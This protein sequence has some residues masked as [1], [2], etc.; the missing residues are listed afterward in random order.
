MPAVYGT[1][2]F[3]EALEYLR[4]KLALPTRRW[5]DLLGAAHDRAFVVAGAVRA[6]LLT[7]LQAAVVKARE[8]GTTLAEFRK[9]FARIAAERGW[10]GWTGE[11]SKGGRAWR[12]RVIYETNLQTSYQAGRYQQMKAVAARRPYW[13]YRHNDAV[14]TPRPEHLAWDGKVL[15]QNDPWWSAHYPPNGWGCRCFVESLSERDM[16]RLDLKPTTGETM[17]YNGMVEQVVPR[18]GEVIEL[19][20]GVDQGWDYQPGAGVDTSLRQLVSDKLIRYPPAITR[21][22]SRD[23]NRY[24]NA[25][26]ETA[27]FVRRALTDGDVVEP[28][29]MG[30]VESFARIQSA[31]GL[32]VR[33][34]M[35]LLPGQ[36]VRHIEKRHAW[37]GKTQRAIR[38]EDYE[39][40]RQVLAEPD[41]LS[42]G[43]ASRKNQP[44]IKVRK[45]MDGEE[46]RCVFEVQSGKHTRALALESLTIKI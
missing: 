35:V 37:D 1:L 42:L 15:R 46:F 3:A 11:G 7:D 40:I 38:P 32:D 33:G 27:A 41:A 26:E 28:L 16:M 17:P 8:K 23:V 34:Y 45:T 13:R 43:T 12:T 19:P 31:L 29:W 21:A 22:L 4:R 14:V 10:T 24:I 44:T 18:T 5:D 20:E 2:P 9:D 36:T 30:F 39:K 6:D 25:K